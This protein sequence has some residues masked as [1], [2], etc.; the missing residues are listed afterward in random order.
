MKRLTYQTPKRRG[1]RGLLRPK[2]FLCRYLLVLLWWWWSAQLEWSTTEVGEKGKFVVLCNFVSYMTQSD[3]NRWEDNKLN[4]SLRCTI[5]LKLCS[6]QALTINL[7]YKLRSFITV[8]SFLKEIRV[9][10]PPSFPPLHPTIHRLIYAVLVVFN[11]NVKGKKYP[12][13]SFTSFRWLVSLPCIFH[14]QNLSFWMVRLLL[15]D[16]V[17]CHSIS[18]SLNKL[19]V[20]VLQI[21]WT[22]SIPVL[23]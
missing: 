4:N 10:F 18:N 16:W 23:E 6:Y 21:L 3:V 14:S 11:V 7:I 20:R 17:Y 12:F 15:W 5:S 13:S 1:R 22:K 8:S 2:W 19:Q 9:I